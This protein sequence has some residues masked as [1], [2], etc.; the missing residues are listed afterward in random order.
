[1]SLKIGRG[2]WQMEQMSGKIDQLL[3]QFDQMD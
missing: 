3:W 1:M 2:S